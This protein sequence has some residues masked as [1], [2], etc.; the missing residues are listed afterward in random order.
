MMM[1]EDTDFFSAMF[2]SIKVVKHNFGP[3]VLW[4]WLIGVL[5]AAGVASL[6]VGLAFVFPLLGHATWHAYRDVRI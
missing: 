3:M 1:H 2:A 4:A 5:I 6:F